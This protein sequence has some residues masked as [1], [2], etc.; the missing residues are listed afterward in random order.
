MVAPWLWKTKSVCS[1]G[2]KAQ[3]QPTNNYFL[4]HLCFS[5]ENPYCSIDL[6]YFGIKLNFI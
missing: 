3:Q 2:K 1:Q 6:I 4:F 5:L